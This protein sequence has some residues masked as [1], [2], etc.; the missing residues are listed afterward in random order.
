MKETFQVSIDER[1]AKWRKRKVNY[2]VRKNLK[3][4]VTLSRMK[5]AQNLRNCLFKIHFNIILLLKSG[6]SKIFPSGF[7]TKIL[8]PIPVPSI[9]ATYLIY[10][11]HS[12]YG[13]TRSS[14]PN[15]G[16]IFAPLHVLQTGPGAHTRGGCEAAGA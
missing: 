12:V 4:V 1:V 9:Y 8:Y 5:P 3:L 11:Y 7:S 10:E 14:S 16:N 13:D 6:S 2:H 15:R